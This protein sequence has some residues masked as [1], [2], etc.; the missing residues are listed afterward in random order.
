[1]TQ[2]LKVKILGSGNAA[3]KQSEAF[4][5]LNQGSHHTYSII[6]DDEP[7]DLVSI[8]T[9]NHMHFQQAMEWLEVAHVIIE[10]PMCASLLQCDKLY[11]RAVQFDHKIF[12]I[13][14]YRYSNHSDFDNAIIIELVRDRKYWKGWRGAWETSLGGSLVLHGIH[15]LDL[16]SWRYG[17]PQSVN[18]RLFG[19][20]S[21]AVETRGL[22]A[23]QWR[24]GRVGTL[25]FAADSEVGPQSGFEGV[26]PWNLGDPIQGYANLFHR[27]SRNL[28]GYP[29]QDDDVPSFADGKNSI[30][31]LTAIYKSSLIDNWIM[32]P[33]LS[34]DE[35][36]SGWT[37][38]SQAWYGQPEPQSLAC[39]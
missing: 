20:P 36:Y 38:Q 8:C 34:S 22:V 13:F 12:P 15:A 24:N 30:E 4:R 5:S 21:V 14:Q 10:K 35:F 19:D 26:T 25:G 7:P 32:L 17:L 33:I 3:N 31:L 23:M 39:H 2:P 9:P 37:Q 28:S 16:F 27:I 11:A 6:L 18:A 1:M 29:I